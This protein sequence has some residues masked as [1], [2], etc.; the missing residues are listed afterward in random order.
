MRSLQFRPLLHSL[1]QQDE[2][3]LIK[4]VVDSPILP[5]LRGGSRIILASPLGKGD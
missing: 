4:L 3:T 1:A 2:K 5:L